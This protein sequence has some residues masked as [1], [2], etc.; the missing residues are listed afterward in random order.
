[1]SMHDKVRNM[2]E[3]TPQIEP[4]TVRICEICG[5][6]T[7]SNSDYICENCATQIRMLL[8]ENRGEEE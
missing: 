1:M 7:K 5:G 8:R 6:S 2:V 3:V 4:N